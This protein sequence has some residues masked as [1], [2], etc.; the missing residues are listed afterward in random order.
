MHVSKKKEIEDFT[1]KHPAARFVFESWYVLASNCDA[2]NIVEL[3]ETFGT[4]DYVQPKS[5]VFNVGGN[6][7][8][9]IATILFDRQQLFIRHVLTHKEYDEWTRENRRK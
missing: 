9:V 6:N 7:Y 2:G 4:V 8:R 3:K 5:Y 1:K